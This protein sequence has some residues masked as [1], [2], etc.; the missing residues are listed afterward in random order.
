M[1]DQGLVGGVIVK[2]GGDQTLVIGEP[3][4]VLER[5]TIL[6]EESYRSRA[7]RVTANFFINRG[8]CRKPAQKFVETAAAYWPANRCL[9]ISRERRKKRPI[10][11]IAQSAVSKPCI[12]CVLGLG[13]NR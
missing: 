13:M 3:A 7:K 6:A 11:V 12:D 10:G 2:H 5:A 9:S 8:F 1:A 4:C